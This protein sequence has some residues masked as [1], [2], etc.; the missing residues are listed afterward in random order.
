M[1]RTLSAAYPPMASYD[2]RQ[3][4]TTAEDLAHYADF[5]AAALYVDDGAL[6]TDFVTWTAGVLRAR[7]VPDGAVPAALDVFAGELRDFPAPAASLPRRPP[8]SPARRSRAGDR[9]SR[10]RSPYGAERIDAITLPR[11]G[12]G[13]DGSLYDGAPFRSVSSL[14]Q[15]RYPALPATIGVAMIS[16]VSYE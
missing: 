6:F 1:T 5:L 11:S 10:R 8:P 15:V 7:G 9:T 14:I 16:G 12:P 4:E 3:M 2:A 13:H